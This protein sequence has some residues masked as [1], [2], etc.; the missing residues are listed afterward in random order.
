MAVICMC[1]PPAHYKLYRLNYSLLYSLTFNFPLPIPR[2]VIQSLLGLY[3]GGLLVFISV[4]TI[5]NVLN[6]SSSPL[7]FY[8][9]LGFGFI[10]VGDMREKQVVVDIDLLLNTLCPISEIMCECVWVRAMW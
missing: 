5:Y 3:R 8:I 9:L 1:L 2:L 10:A 7:S 6:S 4:N